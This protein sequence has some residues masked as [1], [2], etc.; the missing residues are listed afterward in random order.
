MRSAVSEMPAIRAALGTLTA[1]LLGYLAVLAFAPTLRESVPTWLRWFGAP[2]SALTVGITALVLVLLAIALSRSAGSRRPGAPIAI[3]VG[4]ALISVAL[5]MAS[6]WRCQDESRPRFFTALFW[7]AELV[8]GNGPEQMFDSQVCPWPP[9]VALHIAQLCALAAVFLSV[10]GVAM[11]LFRSSLD[12][13]RVY[14]APSVTAVLDLDEDAKPMVTAIK[15]T[16]GRST[17]AVLTDTPDAPCI[18]EA[19]TRGARIVVVDFTRP[20]TWLSLPLWRKLDALYLMSANPSVNIAR[21]G[22]LTEMLAKSA[23]RQRLPL[24]MRIDDPWQATA[25]RAQ[26]FGSDDHRWAPDAVGRYEVTARRLLDRIIVNPDIERILI[27]GASQLTLA[28]CADLAQ[29]QLENDY[30]GRSNLPEVDLIAADAESYR[31]DHEFARLRVGL[32]HDKPQIRAVAE[33]PTVASLRSHLDT[34]GLDPAKVAIVLVDVADLFGL[35]T[36]LA[37]R[38]PG[39]A[40]YAWDPAARAGEDRTP[41]I[42][43]LQTYQ[44]SMDLPDDQAHDAWELA[45]R[46]IHERYAKPGGSP[47]TRPWAELGDFYRESNRRQVSNALWMVEKCGGHTW[48]SIGSSGK[49]W[50][51]SQLRDL[52]PRDQLRTMGFSDDAIDAM[53]RAEHEDWCRFY[54]RHGWTHGTTRDDAKKRH[55]NLVDWA[56]VQNDPEKLDRALS[57]LAA[58]LSKLRELGYSSH[59]VDTST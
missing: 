42:G 1:V 54:R 44:L 30:Y 4:L 55:P 56:E 17:L 2:N 10:I 31:D 15:R 20:Q 24:V 9:P 36:R 13:L 22:A 12:R 28:L 37:A 49:S 33:A 25:W 7:T 26:Q 16:L 35:G 32:P 38:L 39:T 50:S 8:K 53:A 40:I 52:N 47:A 14:L 51:N 27:C 5:G 3:V 19:R 58:T 45:A 57:S 18:N 41:L 6:Y 23:D 48:N 34:A 43:R 29:R 11:A 21:L 46:L 59:P